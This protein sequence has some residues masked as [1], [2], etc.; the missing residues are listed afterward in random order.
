MAGG[1]WEDVTA[2]LRVS[3]LQGSAWPCVLTAVL[4]EQ[5]F[6][7]AAAHRGVVPVTG[8]A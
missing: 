6:L 3:L 8:E 5:L 1:A 2:S 4:C 7:L